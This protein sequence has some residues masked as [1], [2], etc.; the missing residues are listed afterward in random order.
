[1]NRDYGVQVAR[2]AGVCF[3][4]VRHEVRRHKESSDAHCNRCRFNDLE[5]KAA[6]D[7]KSNYLHRHTQGENEKWFAPVAFQVPR[8]RDLE[9]TG[10]ETRHLNYLRDLRSNRKK[11]PLLYQSGMDER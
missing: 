8:D 11:N 5:S 6:S 7:K 1:M 2:I 10:S 4:G 9:R 3:A